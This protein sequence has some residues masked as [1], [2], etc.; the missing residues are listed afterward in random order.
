MSKRSIK[1]AILNYSNTAVFEKREKN[2]SSEK[3]ISY[4]SSKML[5]NNQITKKKLSISKS[6]I[7]FPFC[8]TMTSFHSLDKSS[9]VLPLLSFFEND[10]SKT[11]IN[12]KKSKYYLLNDNNFLNKTDKGNKSEKHFYITETHHI[13][14]I[15]KSSD[16]KSINNS[17][18]NSVDKNKVRKDLDIET[19]LLIRNNPNKGQYHNSFSNAKNKLEKKIKLNNFKH[20]SNL[21]IDTSKNNIEPK[22]E[23]YTF[24]CSINDK[25]EKYNHYKYPGFKDFIEKTQELKINSYTSKIKKERAIRMEEGYSNHIEFYQD[26]MNSLQ[27]AKKLLDIN[28]SNKMADYIRF[29]IYKKEK[30]IVK[31]SKLLQEIIDY[32]RD[33]EHINADIK[34]IETEKNNIIK[35]IYF[36]IQLKEKKL[37]LPSFYINIIEN[38]TEKRKTLKQSTRKDDKKEI[39]SMKKKSI[40]RPSLSHINFTY[41]NKENNENNNSSNSS[42]IKKEEYKRILS[43]S[44]NL[45]FKTPE[46]FFEAFSNLEKKDINLMNYNNNL[47]NQL[48]QLK[49]E[50]KSAESIN[51]NIEEYNQNLILKT[52]QLNNLKSLVEKRIHLINELKKIKNPEFI[53]NKGIYNK[54]NKSNDL[55]YKKIYNIFEVCKYFKHKTKNDNFN[56][57]SNNKNKI[58][59][60]K[61]I[62]LML[63]YIEHIIDFLITK[64]IFDVNKGEDNRNL[65]KKMKNDIEKEH[66]MNKTKLLKMIDSEK[67]ILL[68]EKLIKKN[69]KIYI[70]NSRKIDWY[71][72]FK[73]SKNKKKFNNDSNG[74][75]TIQDY[76]YDETDITK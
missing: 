14:K 23:E 75:P 21:K 49:K 34:K 62:I 10:N 37:V 26:T 43:Y 64:F 17:I 55:I 20:Y 63:E 60:E 33:I 22:R 30:E 28:F 32:R 45:I 74:E 12:K 39:N 36:Q 52:N 50:L 5:K 72:K 53:I 24:K 6:N 59:K 68:K 38:W 66:K 3:V 42:I 27:S 29:L 70:L 40:R 35:W 25:I 69:N 46:E 31:S 67:I 44:N 13:N 56:F 76:L 65:I 1:N 19:L 71:N 7:L 4:K 9:S 58:S 11:K 41:N 16:L 8:Q 15:K 51:D 73:I 61:E 47:Y 18:N 2:F 48:F 57:N 54:L